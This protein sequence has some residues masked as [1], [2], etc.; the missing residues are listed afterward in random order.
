MQIKPSEFITNSVSY[1]YRL[2]DPEKF[3]L[4]KKKIANFSD[5]A[6]LQG[7]VDVIEFGGQVVTLFQNGYYSVSYV[8]REGKIAKTE[9]KL[10]YDKN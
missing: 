3:F 7:I 2:A 5:L 10:L 4:G 6:K 1:H 9:V 8:D